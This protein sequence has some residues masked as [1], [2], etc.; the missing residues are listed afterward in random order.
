MQARAFAGGDDEGR[1]PRALGLRNFDVA[2]GAERRRHAVDG[3]AGLAA[4]AFEIAAGDGDAQTLRAALQE[5]SDRFDRTIGAGRI[6]GIEALH[7]VIG[8]REIARRARERAEMIEAGDKRE[9][10][11]RASAGHRSA[12]SPK[13]PHSDDGTRIE[14]LVSEP[15]ASGTRPPPTAAPEPPDE[16]PRH[17]RRDRADCARRRHE[18]FRR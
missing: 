17:A 12:L 2:V 5:R 18:C 6:V 9:A 4:V 3:V 13:M 10:C 15:S 8:K 7:G 1:R 14:P 11:A 16:P